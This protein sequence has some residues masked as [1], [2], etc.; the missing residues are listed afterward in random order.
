MK[1]QKL[2]QARGIGK[3]WRNEYERKLVTAEEAVKVVKS[4]D[5]VVFPLV[6][7]CHTLGA[8]LA[9]RKDELRDVTFHSTT[10]TQA[11]VGMFYELGMQEAFQCTIEL[12]IGDFVRASS[13]G[14]DEKYTMYHPGL[15]SNLM[16]SFDERPEECPFTIDV[17]MVTVSPP[18]KDGF[19]SFG[20][21]LWNKRSYC[22]RAR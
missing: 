5:R 16:K 10:P 1:D 18:D 12:F 13:A 6:N 3:D 14:S 17:V 22:Q 7:G 9:A 19:C 20:R 2:V 8:A 11:D 4:G 15:F 21:T